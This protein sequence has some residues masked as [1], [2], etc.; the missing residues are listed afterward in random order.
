[1]DLLTWEEGK[2]SRDRPIFERRRYY[3]IGWQEGRLFRNRR[4]LSWDNGNVP[5]GLGREYE[6]RIFN[7]HCLFR[8]PFLQIEKGLLVKSKIPSKARK[9]P[10][11]WRSMV[12]DSRK[13]DFYRDGDPWRFLLPPAADDA[14]PPPVVGPEGSQEVGPRGRV[15]VR[16]LRQGS[17]TRRLIGGLDDCD[18][19]WRRGTATKDD[20]SRVSR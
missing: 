5:E 10:L 2:D 3:L 6:R 20:S 11:D 8:D 1:M 15:S 9:T 12:K 14:V 16:A 18:L 4:G 17:E 13:L 19:L 7:R